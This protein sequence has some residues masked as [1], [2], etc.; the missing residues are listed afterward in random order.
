MMQERP[1]APNSPEQPDDDYGEELEVIAQV[2]EIRQ[3]R[4]A[5]EA[6]RRASPPAT[7]DSPLSFPI[8]PPYRRVRLLGI[9]DADHLQDP[10]AYGRDPGEERGTGK[11]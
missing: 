6:E 5:Q 9:M 8:R 7:E 3:A 11:S 10:E 1:T 4:T 2:T